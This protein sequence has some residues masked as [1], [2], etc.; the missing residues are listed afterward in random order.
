M[1]NKKSF[2]ERLTGSIN[3]E[4]ENEPSEE[5]SSFSFDSAPAPSSQFQVQTTAAKN[6]KK[7]WPDN[8][9]EGQLTIDMHQTPKEIIVQSIVAGLKPEDLDISISR[10][11]VTIKGKRSRQHSASSDD[12]FYQE[13]YW[14][15][16]SRSIIL[17]QEI[18]VDEAEAV[19]KNGV[20]TLTLPKLDKSRIQ[21]IKVKND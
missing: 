21:K 19:L 13:L 10:D 5:N 8:E 1:N 15:A 17:P 3:L 14:G 6:D 4:E 18:D 9:E 16:F 7:K 20:L 12:Y 2:F 11:M